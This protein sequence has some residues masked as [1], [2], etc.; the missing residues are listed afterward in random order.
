MDSLI[1]MPRT[2][3]KS[4]ASLTSEAHHLLLVR[5]IALGFKEPHHRLLD[6]H[7][8]WRIGRWRPTLQPRGGKK[9]IPISQRPELS[10]SR[11]PVRKG[12]PT[13]TTGGV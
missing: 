12:T 2:V 9:L 13:L 3:L 5:E 6:R 1:F 7:R 4:E 10:D 11:Q 8:W